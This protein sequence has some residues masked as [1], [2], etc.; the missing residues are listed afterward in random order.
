M[1]GPIL[2]VQ[3]TQIVAAELEEKR[4]NTKNYRLP[5]AVRLALEATLAISITEPPTVV[6][7]GV[8]QLSDKT[9]RVRLLTAPNG[10]AACALVWCGRFHHGAAIGNV[11]AGG[12]VSITRAFAVH[13]ETEARESDRETYG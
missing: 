2:G 13:Y 6:R 1:R 4:A 11:V 7:R 3:Y 8:R 9:K 10:F 12:L 5:D